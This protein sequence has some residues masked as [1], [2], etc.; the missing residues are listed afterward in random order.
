MTTKADIEPVLAAGLALEQALDQAVADFAQEHGALVRRACQIPDEQLDLVPVVVTTV[1]GH[2]LGRLRRTQGSA[3]T[4][5]LATTLLDQFDQAELRAAQLRT[6]DTQPP[7]D[8]L[9]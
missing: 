4:A 2:V 3:S 7:K 5:R 9:H 1:F 8:S 6:G